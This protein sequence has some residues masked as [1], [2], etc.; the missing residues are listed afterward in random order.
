MRC[1]S[2]RCPP[3]A[4]RRCARSRP[5]PGRT[6]RALAVLLAAALGASA[7]PPAEDK[8]KE[9]SARIVA[10]AAF[11]LAVPAG[12]RT[13][14]KPGGAVLT[15]PFAEGLPAR[16]IV[17]WVR[18]DHPLYGTAEAYMARLTR[19]APIPLKGWRNGP[20]ESA[21]SA[22]RKALRLQR[23]TTEHVPPQGIAPKEVAMR[24]EH[25]AVSAAGGFYLLVYS[26]PRSLDAA[27]RKAFRRLVEKGFKP[28]Y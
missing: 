18:A 28:K 9:R 27:Q 4:R 19:P 15:G 13:E 22:G 1:S 8:T 6:P 20:V 25:L 12:W 11:E 26:A 5:S 10:D 14:R 23:D 16:V 7:A 17:R 3:R 24:E 21:A 2:R